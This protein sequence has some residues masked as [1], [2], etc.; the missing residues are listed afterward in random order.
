VSP[1]S[2]L[3]GKP[4]SHL[5]PSSLRSWL[6]GSTKEPGGF[7][8]NRDKLRVQ[9]LVV[10][11]SMHRLMSTT[12]SCISCHHAA[13]TWSRLATGSIDPSLLVSPPR[14]PHKAKIFSHLLFTCTNANQVTTCTYNTRLRVS[15][16]HVVNHSSLGSDHPPVLRCSSPDVSR[17]VLNLVNVTLQSPQGSWNTRRAW[18]HRTPARLHL[19]RSQECR[20]GRK[21]QQIVLVK[22]I[23]YLLYLN[24]SINV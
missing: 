23:S 14:R 7:V 13:R 5:R 4:R 19:G 15:P 9:T 22:H 18:T 6:C 21:L 8:V 11:H 17:G 1:A 24:N 3:L 2:K 10:S 20:S 12:S 16:Y